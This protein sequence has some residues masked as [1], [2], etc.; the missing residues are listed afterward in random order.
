MTRKDRRLSPYDRA[1]QTAVRS[2]RARPLSW[3]TPQASWLIHWRL[4]ATSREDDVV[5]VIQPLPRA[6]VRTRAPARG[7]SRLA[8]DREWSRAATATVKSDI[9]CFIRTYVPQRPSRQCGND[10]ALES[11]LTEL[12]LIKATGKRDGFRFVRGPKAT[13]GHGVFIWALLDFWSRH[14]E[15]T[16][17]LSFE[18]IAHAPG[19]PGRVFLLDENDVVDRLAAVGSA[20]GGLLS[21]SETAG[22]KQVVRDP[23]LDFEATLSHI[24]ADYLGTGRRE[25][26]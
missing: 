12:G 26:A 17:T 8:K 20:T 23:A 16:T 2:R 22:L 25:A 15:L 7:L 6:H 4:A 18:A 10:D 9:A 5:L 19:G 1:R 11:P 13:L 24:D 14:S 3:N 21:W